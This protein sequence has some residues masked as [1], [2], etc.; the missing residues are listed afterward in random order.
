MTD[1]TIAKIL[2][3]A[4]PPVDLCDLTFDDHFVRSL[5]ADPST[6][7]RPR[8]VRDA[9]YSWVK[10]TPVSAPRLLAWSDDAGNLLGI[11]RPVDATRAA[12]EVLADN[13]NFSRDIPTG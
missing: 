12:V 8:Q 7:N 5:P 1:P 4:S 3:S 10:P 11:A 2:T 13:G 6:V 9:C